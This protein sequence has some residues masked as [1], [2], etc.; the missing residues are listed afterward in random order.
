LIQ[1]F[2][3]TVPNTVPNDFLG[4]ALGQ[5]PGTVS[6]LGTVCPKIA[7]VYE[8]KTKKL[9]QSWD[10]L[11]KGQSLSHSPRFFRNGGGGWNVSQNASR[12]R[13]I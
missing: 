9:G 8:N 3:T 11:Q 12:G 1:T 2:K 10:S 13:K 5:C 6:Q 7:E 4:T